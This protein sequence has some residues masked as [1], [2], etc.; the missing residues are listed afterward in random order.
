MAQ[1]GSDELGL[2]SGAEAG[3]QNVLRDDQMSHSSVA[4]EP[5]SQSVF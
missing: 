4:Q 2:V 1:H 3:L 5:L